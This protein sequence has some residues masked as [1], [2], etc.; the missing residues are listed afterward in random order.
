MVREGINAE[1]TLGRVLFVTEWMTP[2]ARSAGAVGIGVKFTIPKKSE[3]SFGVVWFL[4]F[5]YY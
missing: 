4:Y 2:S 5:S 1:N 3:V